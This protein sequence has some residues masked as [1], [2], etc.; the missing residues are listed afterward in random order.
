MR[1]IS[2]PVA[3]RQASGLGEQAAQE[4][5]GVQEVLQAV[6]QLSPAPCG[7][8]LRA[9]ECRR[10]EAQQ[11]VLAGRS[12]AGEVGVASMPGDL[13]ESPAEVTAQSIGGVR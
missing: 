2:S 11:N 6:S 7:I 4:G 5:E 3:R 8:C 10:A 12:V 9:R 13:G 1:R